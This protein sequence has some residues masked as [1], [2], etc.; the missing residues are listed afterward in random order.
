MSLCH[1][2]QALLYE[3]AP[4]VALVHAVLRRA[5][6]ARRLINQTSGMLN[7]GAVMAAVEGLS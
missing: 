6:G 3:R 1:D 4:S 7:C 5:L 2:V